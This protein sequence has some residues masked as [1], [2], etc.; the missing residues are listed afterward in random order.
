MQYSL[1]KDLQHLKWQQLRSWISSPDCRVAMDKQQTQYQLTP[2]SKWKIPQK[3][4]NT[5]QVRKSRYLGYVYHDTNGLNH[6]PVWKIQ[7]F[8]LSEIF[9]GHPL[10]GLF[11]E[12]QFEKVLL[13]HCWERVPNWKCLFVYREKELF[14]SLYMDH[15]KLAGKKT[16]PWPNVESIDETSRF[17]VNQHNSLTT[18]IWIA[19]NENVKKSRDVVDNYR[20]MFESRIS[21]GAK[22]KQ[23]CSGKLG[24]DIC[25]WS[26]DMDSHAKKCVERYYELAIKQLSN[27]TK[28]QF[29]ALMQRIVKSLLSNRPVVPA[30][31]THW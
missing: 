25:S 18:S 28:F 24:A 12:K 2:R 13:E 31:G 15:I 29:H 23:H 4:L 8:L 30:F 11:W 16:K 5:S 20:N 14:V 7:S 10:A 6:G 21:A 27:H 26:Y 19:L 9:Y 22:E 17:W 3:L 1:N